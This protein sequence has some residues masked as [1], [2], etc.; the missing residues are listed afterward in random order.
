MITRHKC[1]SRVPY[2]FRVHASFTNYLLPPPLPTFVSSVSFIL[3]LLPFFSSLFLFMFFSTRAFPRFSSSR[4]FFSS[5]S[6]LWR[7]E[8]LLR[9]ELSFFTLIS[10][11]GT[12]SVSHFAASHAFSSATSRS[13][14]KLHR[15][16]E[17]SPYGAY[18]FALA[19]PH[20][21]PGSGEKAKEAHVR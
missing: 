18:D 3:F 8:A 15:H 4:I 13:S 17:I 16:R 5:Y 6:S 1:E 2:E 19:S 12:L 11:P 10:W 14:C 9:A 7:E 20:S 21:R